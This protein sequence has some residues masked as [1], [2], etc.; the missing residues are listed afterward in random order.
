MIK[1]EWYS[2]QE[3][4][5]TVD[6]LENFILPNLEMLRSGYYPTDPREVGRPGTNSR[7]C[8]KFV[9]AAEL[10]AEIDIRLKRLNKRIAI[11][12]RYIKS[13]PWNM[14]EIAR[15]LNMDEE[16]LDAEIWLMLCY[17]AGKRRKVHDFAVWKCKIKKTVKI[18]V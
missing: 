2:P 5:P 6:Q 17:L 3:I 13:P 10:A 18:T 15:E 11:T 9:P 1:K 7:T 8:A 14:A 4:V 16:K 12:L